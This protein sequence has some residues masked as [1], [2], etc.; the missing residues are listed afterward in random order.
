MSVVKRWGMVTCYFKNAEVQEHFTRQHTGKPRI[1]FFF[2]FFLCK[3]QTHFSVT[4]TALG[5]LEPLSPKKPLTPQGFQKGPA[6]AEHSLLCCNSNPSL[7]PYP[8]V[9][10]EL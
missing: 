3:R 4:C 1:Y 8:P 10:T 6:S 2:F 5:S 9:Q 7:I